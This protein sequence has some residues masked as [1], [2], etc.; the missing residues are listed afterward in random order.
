LEPVQL[1]MTLETVQKMA[2]Q[3]KHVSYYNYLKDQSF[4]LSDYYDADH[5]NEDGSRKLTLRI[6]EQI[7][8]RLPEVSLAR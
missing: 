4:E 1:A 8:E 7:K 3:H 6:N 5:L 2:N